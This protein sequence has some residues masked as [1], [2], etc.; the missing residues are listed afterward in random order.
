MTQEI[1]VF[2]FIDASPTASGFIVAVIFIIVASL[3]LI[4]N[5]IKECKEK[6]G[7]FYEH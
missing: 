4:L 2:D 3:V 5:C 7:A 1:N 6:K